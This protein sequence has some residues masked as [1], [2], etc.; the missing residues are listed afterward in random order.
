MFKK[1][2]LYK[3]VCY[4]CYQCRILSRM[5]MLNTSNWELLYL[6]MYLVSLCISY[7]FFCRSDGYMADEYKVTPIMS[8]YLLAFVVGDFNYT[9]STTRTGIKVRVINIYHVWI[10]PAFFIVL[11][12]LTWL[13][14]VSWQE[15]HICHEDSN[16]TAK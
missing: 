2:F 1:D 14:I 12:V 9:N 3:C 10:C 16:P 5:K 7:I 11:R 13:I 15:W 4:K 6:T 8:T